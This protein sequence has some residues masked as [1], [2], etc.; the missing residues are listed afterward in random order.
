MYSFIEQHID[1]SWW[2]NP[3]LNATF[4][5]K[6][7]VDKYFQNFFSKYIDSERPYKAFEHEEP[8]YQKHATYTFDF[9]VFE[10][11][12]VIFW[13]KGLEGTLSNREQE[14]KDESK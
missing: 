2:Y 5:T 12:G 8:L 11:G 10:L 6:E 13:P 9:K 1:G 3:R 7:E 14:K 4:E